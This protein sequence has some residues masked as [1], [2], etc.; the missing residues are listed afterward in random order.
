MSQSDYEKN[1]RFAEIWIK[2]FQQKALSKWPY[3]EWVKVGFSYSESREKSMLFFTLKP[4]KKFAKGISSCIVSLN[5]PS[6]DFIN[7]MKMAFAMIRD[8]AIEI[9]NEIELKNRN[10]LNSHSLVPRSS[11]NAKDDKMVA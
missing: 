9:Q 4:P 1:L 2:N 3:L 11:Q 7:E 5:L 6:H 8:F 10:G